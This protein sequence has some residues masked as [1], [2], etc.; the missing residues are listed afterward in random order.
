MLTILDLSPHQP[1]PRLCKPIDI[2]RC[3][4]LEMPLKHG[5]HVLWACAIV[6]RLDIAL[7]HP[8]K[9][10][11]TIP[12]TNI[13]VHQQIKWCTAS[14]CCHWQRLMVLKPKCSRQASACRPAWAK[15]QEL[16][17]NDPHVSRDCVPL[18]DVR[19]SFWETKKTLK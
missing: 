14:T 13:H 11:G 1:H 8:N 6:K 15:A 19:T 2:W 7:G 12:E 9:G 3:H 17:G 4:V 16:E 18:F 10:T 5:S